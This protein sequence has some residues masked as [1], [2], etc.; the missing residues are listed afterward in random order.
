[1]ILFAHTGVPQTNIDKAALLMQ[2]GDFANAIQQLESAIG[3][4]D[5]P[6]ER[7]RLEAELGRAQMIRNDYG[8]TREKLLEGLRLRIPDFRDEELDLWDREGRFDARDIDGVRQYL[9]PSASNLLFRY[10]DVQRRVPFRGHPIAKRLATEA[11]ELA[12]L[13]GTAGAGLVRP[14]RFHIRMRVTYDAAAIPPMGN[15][16]CWIPIPRAFPHQTDFELLRTHPKASWI[17]HSLSE[18]RTVHFEVP[19]EAPPRTDLW[20]EVE[21]R[22]TC[23]ARANRVDADR[24]ADVVP[25][26]IQPFAQE[27]PPHIVFTE[28]MRRL[29]DEIAGPRTNPAEIARALYDW[30]VENLAYSYAPEYGTIPNIGEWVNERRYGDCGQM[31]LFYMTLCRIKGIP[32]RWQSGWMLFPEMVNL[33]DWCEI[34]LEPYG[35]LPVDVSMADS[36]RSSRLLDEATKRSVIDFGFGSMDHWRMM[37]NARHGVA[38]TPAKTS[39]RTD[40]VDSQRGELEGNGQTVPFSDFDYRLEVVESHLIEET[41]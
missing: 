3:N 10:P 36:A 30:S 12:P 6:D 29:A 8:L 16:R 14:R 1:M 9:K 4:A 23:Y 35:W 2:S 32:T 22:Y 15:V 34:Y 24:V 13:A 38:H 11:Q 19:V 26:A 31:T 40:P 27:E 20:F 39:W 33:H 28:S 41:E 21:Y 17:G 37:A 7:R 25:S 18:Q 5:T